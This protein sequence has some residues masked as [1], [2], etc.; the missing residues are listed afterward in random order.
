MHCKCSSYQP[1]ELSSKA[2]TKRMRETRKILRGLRSVAEFSDDEHELY[3]CEICRQMW[4]VSRAWG[5]RNHRYAFQV[6]SIE[7]ED[8]LE[9]PYVQPD[10]LLVFK[11][12]MS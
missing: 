1:L 6:P 7:A 9:E 2:V 12:M 4:Q 3:L 8:W 11:S 10:E 5:W